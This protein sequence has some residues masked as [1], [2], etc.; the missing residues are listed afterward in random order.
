MPRRS[1]SYLLRWRL[2]EAT[3]KRYDIA[4]QDMVKWARRHG[5]HA[6]T[7]EEL[8]EL[9][10]GYIHYLYETGGS[11]SAANNDQRGGQ[12]HAAVSQAVS[13]RQGGSGGLE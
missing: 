9:I 5:E 2:K 6:A 11:K 12:P 4:V 7:V 13:S 8:D 1:S 10:C 3:M